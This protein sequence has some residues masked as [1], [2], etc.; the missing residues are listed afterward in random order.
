[1]QFSCSS[2][3][4]SMFR[5]QAICEGCIFYTGLH[6]FIARQGMEWRRHHSHE[7]GHCTEQSK[8]KEHSSWA[9]KCCS[10]GLLMRYHLTYHCAN[11]VSDY[12]GISAKTISVHGITTCYA[13]LLGSVVRAT[14][15]VTASKGGTMPPRNTALV[16]SSAFMRTCSDGC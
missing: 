4:C 6:L 13:H 5:Q 9:C 15:V 7:Q 11:D 10:S 2:G 8:S 3:T 16:T 1:M 12:P 14:S